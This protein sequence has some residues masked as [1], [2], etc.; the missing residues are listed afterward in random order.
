MDDGRA[1]LVGQG[2]NGRPD[3]VV[4]GL[5]A[6]HRGQRRGVDFNRRSVPAAVIDGLALGDDVQPGPKVVAA[7]EPGIGAK[8]RQERFLETVL[9]VGR[10][11]RGHQE[12]MEFGRVVIDE[13]LEG[14]EMHTG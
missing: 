7:R 14:R 2:T 11:D 1:L 4:S 12:P 3:A 8:G 13:S 10:P 5:G 9:G 6:G